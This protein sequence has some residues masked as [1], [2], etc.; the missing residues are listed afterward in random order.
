MRDKK[1][2]LDG[3]AVVAQL[4]SWCLLLGIGLMLLFVVFFGV[5]ISNL[6]TILTKATPTVLQPG[7]NTPLTDMTLDF[8]FS[9]FLGLSGI[10]VLRG[11]FR[12]T[13]TIVKY[14]YLCRIPFHHDL[15]KCPQCGRPLESVSVGRARASGKQRPMP[16][17][18]KLSK[19][20]PQRKL[21]DHAV[22]EVS[23]HPT[24]EFVDVFIS[25]VEEDSNIALQLALGLEVAGYATWCYEVDALPGAFYV[26]QVGK[27]I[28]KCQVTLLIVSPHSLGSNQ[29]TNEVVRAYEEGKY[30][31][32]VLSD[33]TDVDFKR[34]QPVW[35]QCI[36]GATSVN[37]PI[38]GVEDLTA[39]IVNGIKSLGVNPTSKTDATRIDRIRNML[40]NL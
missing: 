5:G 22:M 17:R 19:A 8:V 40:G 39:L 21:D 7:Q 15:S 35:R 23:H 6:V 38:Q 2:E 18:G 32:P 20:T 28:E 9:V 10:I 26:E 14:C 30:F 13:W 36:G 12:R 37:I 31:V 33:I 4:P 25:H 3:N 11:G 1:V 34:R 29:V 24:R 27:A 16:S